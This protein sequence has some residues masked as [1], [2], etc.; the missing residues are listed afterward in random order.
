MR[1]VVLVVLVVFVSLLV[2]GCAG[3]DAA[4]DGADA[5][6]DT[7]TLV[8]TDADGVV[9]R[10]DPL[11][12]SS[13]AVSDAAAPGIGVQATPSHDG[14]VVVWTELEGAEP[15]VAVADGSGTER[16]P[17]PTPPFFY[18]FSPDDERLVALGNDP[19]GEGVA[20]LVVDRTE[21][22]VRQVDAGSP[23]FVAWSPT[24]DG[25]GAHIGGDSLVT[26]DPAGERV[27]I[28]ATPGAFQAPEWTPDGR[29]LAVVAAE[30]ATVGIGPG[31]AQTSSSTL[32][33]VDPDTGAAEP[34][35]AVAGPTAFE[36]GAEGRVAM[37]DGVGG[38]GTM[39]GPLVVVDDGTSESVA[40]DV[41]AF[42]WSPD[43][44]RLLYYTLDP[45]LGVAPHTWD[46]ESVSDYP[47]FLPT[48]VF[49]NEYLPFWSQYTRTITQWAPDGS[50]FAYA[51]AGV[52][53]GE[54]SAIWV[55]P[56]DG[57]RRETVPGEMV[58]WA[59]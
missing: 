3:D 10:V 37:V 19:G 5:G 27:R 1:P 53:P 49:L 15:V 29:L 17:S 18:M 11:D 35:A 8:V 54:S 47:V 50:S 56:L 7:G 44:S 30:G 20:L 46:G 55:Q 36:L 45:D 28:D 52:E 2:A 9:S 32:A 58:V 21:P 25:L 43:G 39:L 41:V 33:Y 57:E 51:A 22:A 4:P 24:G 42:E 14:E 16:I 59:P 38:S 40:E 6:D 23:Y 12:G 13:T 48:A 26:V 31:T 34:L